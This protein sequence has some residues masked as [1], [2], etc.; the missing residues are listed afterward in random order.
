MLKK[1]LR[2][3]PKS[4]DVLVE[5]FAGSCSVALNT[6]Y[7]K[8]LLNDANQDIITLYILARDKPEWLISQLKVLFNQE[9]NTRARYIQ[10]RRIYNE[11][12]CNKTR[13]I[14]L[15][16]LS[17]HCYNGLVRYN[18][19]GVFNVNFAGYKKPYLPED[20]IRFFSRKM[21]NAEFFCM[22]F[23]S[24]IELASGREGSKALY[25][26]P[27]YLPTS[28]GT[29]SFTQYTAAGFPVARHLDI[30]NAIISTR[31]VFDSAFV[32]NHAAPLLDVSYPDYK[33]K[34]IFRVSRTISCKSSTRVP[35][36]E[37]LLY[38]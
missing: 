33:K 29:A 16:F 6:N 32:S 11:C 25:C 10:I 15:C 26:D 1:L 30:N 31:D 8:Y 37:V 7:D 27:P 35:T 12:R 18:Q 23:Q 20:E 4:G 28:K 24:F 14:L 21:K 13:A 9:N 22:D 19:S 38:Y 5:P 2:H 17:R 36:S 34:S 3:L